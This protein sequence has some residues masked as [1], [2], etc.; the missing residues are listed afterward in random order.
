LTIAIQE[1]NSSMQVLKS[2]GVMSIAR[3]MGLIYGGMGLLFAPFFLL[4]AILG[5]VAG[6][7]KNPMAGVLGIVFAIA[8]PFL[9]GL[10]GFVMGALGGLLYNWLSKWVGGVEL[11]LELHPAGPVAPY[12]IMPP[13]TPV[14]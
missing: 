4:F 2:V 10:T 5:S 9:Y 7:N 6:Q 13:A 11:E 8:M 1:R 3:I 14:A 12:P